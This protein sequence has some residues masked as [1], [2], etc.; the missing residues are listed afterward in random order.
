MKVEH[1]EKTCINCNRRIYLNP[2]N[3]WRHSDNKK[4]FCR[5]GQPAYADP[6]DAPKKI[7]RGVIF[8]APDYDASDENGNGEEQWFVDLEGKLDGRLGPFTTQGDAVDGLTK[9]A[10]DRKLILPGLIIDIVT[11]P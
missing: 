10:N 1:V 9:W 4:I 2:A 5:A 11:R 6:G 8:N 7:G 3:N